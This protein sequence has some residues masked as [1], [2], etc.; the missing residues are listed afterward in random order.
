[1]KISVWNA[2]VFH[3]IKTSCLWDGLSFKLVFRCISGMK[4]PWNYERASKRTHTFFFCKD[5]KENKEYYP[6]EVRNGKM[7][8]GEGREEMYGFEKNS[9]W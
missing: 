9:I 4:Y 3:Q 8:I 2:Y 1:M 7:A 5:W 6:E